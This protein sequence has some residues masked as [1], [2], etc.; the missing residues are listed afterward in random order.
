VIAWIALSASILA[1]VLTALQY[2]NDRRGTHREMTPDVVSRWTNTDDPRLCLILVRD[3]LEDK[4]QVVKVWLPQDSFADESGRQVS[5]ETELEH[6]WPLGWVWELPPLHSS[7]FR[8]ADNP[9]SV[10]V[11][12][13]SKRWKPWSVTLQ[14]DPPP[15]TAV[16]GV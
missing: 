14:V 16:F 9:I 5:D 13:R 11:T 8:T 6:P 2:V 7:A 10:V 4:D 3:S 1:L 15:R 12:F